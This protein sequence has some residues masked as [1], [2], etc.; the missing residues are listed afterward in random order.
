MKEQLLRFTFYAII[1]YLTVDALNLTVDASPLFGGN[2]TY[3]CGVT[4]NPLNKRYSDQFSNR[5]YA[6]TFAANLNVGEPR[7]VR[8]IYFLPNDRAYNADVVQNM[9]ADIRTIQ[10]FYAE[11]M[12]AHGFGNTPLRIETDPQGEP[13]VHRVDGEHPD[14]HYLENTTNS[15]RAEI[16]KKFDIYANIYFIVIDNSINGLGWFGGQIVGGVGGRAGK[17]GGYVLKAPKFGWGVTA[18]ELGHAFGLWHDFR[19][20]AYIMSYGPGMNRLS[21]CHAEYLSV[22]PYFNA[23]TPIERGPP[24]SI[25]LISSHIYPAESKNVPV[26]L[27][28]SDSDELHQVILHARA[29]VKACRE[30]RGKNESVVEFDYD[31]VIPSAREPS[32]SIIAGLLDHLVHP[33]RIEAVDMNGNADSINFVLLSEA[34]QPLSK[35]SGDNQHGLPNTPLPV[36]FVVEVRD[37]NNGSVR[38]GVPVTFTVTA[39]DGTLSRERTETNASG[40]A[41]SLLTLGPHLGV[42]TVEVSAAGMTVTFT[43]VARLEIVPNKITGP[44]L[45]MIAATAPG[46]GGAQSNNVDSLAA[47]SSGNVTEA[48]VAA[49]GAKE[50]DAVG[51]YVWTLGKI[52]E[53]GGNNINDVINAIGLAQGNVNDHSSYALITLES[54]TIQPNVMMRVGS[55]DSI[56]VWLNGEVVHNNSINRWAVDFQDRFAVNLK[57]GDNLLLVKVSERSGGWNMFV[58]IEADVNAVY[59]RPPDT[60]VSADVNSDGLVNVLD[61]ILIASNLGQSGQE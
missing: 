35:I 56:K 61:L 31:D 38:N 5:R 33:I 8:M 11:Q 40:Q 28:I 15:V 50:G 16:E 9:K 10:T 51:S 12:G 49:N 24:P 60:V 52:A 59:K 14:S 58:G 19:D 53:T 21:A 23:N 48:D 47:A 3:F 20:G 26:R 44:W 27:R 42:N 43:A 41:E 6:R 34:L 29:T 4:D 36:P 7:T 37:L 30:L 22:H 17:N 45:W 57:E 1:I 13:I 55:D 25:E 18:H 2:G 46:Q 54:I 32:N 39:G